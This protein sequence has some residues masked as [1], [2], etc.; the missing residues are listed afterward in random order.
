M[1]TIGK[2]EL[3]TFLHKGRAAACATCLAIR[4]DSGH[5]VK[6]FLD[7]AQ[8]VAELQYL[9]RDHVVLFR[10]QGRDYRNQK[11]YTTLKPTMF[12][13]DRGLKSNPSTSVLS[14]RY[15]S[16]ERAESELVRQ[17]ELSEHDGA[18]RLARQR[19]LRW[20]ILQHYGVCD[21]PLLDVTS[22]LRV[23]VSF[24]AL[25][26]GSAKRRQAYVFVLGVPNISGAITA[27][28]EAGVH[29]IRLASACPPSALRPHVQDGYLIGEYPEVS[30]MSQKAQYLHVEIDCGRRLIAKFRFDPEWFQEDRDFP[31]ISKNALYPNVHDP[32][33]NL[34]R[35][36]KRAAERDTNVS[37]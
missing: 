14:E 2:Q 35:D 5:E 7:L 8:K 19:V 25:S 23:A 17:Y 13:P 36:V 9:N 26:S 4:K 20:A 16:L 21:T 27:S 32:L 24:A 22:S 34:T 11:R 29:I 3:R 15:E 1:E 18:D 37:P 31:L 6:S 10:G 30:S 28:A 12:R 33:F